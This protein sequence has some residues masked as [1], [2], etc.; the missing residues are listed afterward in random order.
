[1][2]TANT[3]SNACSDAVTDDMWSGA[4]FSGKD[5]ERKIAA[6][7][8]RLIAIR[9]LLKIVFLLLPQP[10]QHRSPCHRVSNV[11]GFNSPG[12]CIYVFHLVHFP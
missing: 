11:R 6:G 1:M 7:F 2:M 3:P 9:V 4:S 5:M 12:I 8:K 10:P